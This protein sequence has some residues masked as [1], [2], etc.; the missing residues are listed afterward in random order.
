MEYDNIGLACGST[1]SDILI[2][3]K[4][5][6]FDFT[7]PCIIHDDCYG[8]KG[9][10]E[11]K[12]K[13]D[14]DKQFLRDMQAVCTQ[15]GRTGRPSLSSTPRTIYPPPQLSMSFA[16]AQM[17]CSTASGFQSVLY[18]I[19]VDSTIL[20]SRSSFILTGNDILFPS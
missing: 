9:K 4:P 19:R 17:K 8:C 13:L 3:D 10:N 20:C 15:T 7:Q 18:S 1:Y 11:G 2:P 12:I 16:N 14:C 5:S 6:G